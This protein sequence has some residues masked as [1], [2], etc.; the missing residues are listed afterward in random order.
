MPAHY[1]FHIT[2]EGNRQHVRRRILLWFAKMDEGYLFHAANGRAYL[3]ERNEASKIV[4]DMQAAIEN[5]FDKAPWTRADSRVISLAVLAG[6]LTVTIPMQNIWLLGAN[7]LAL[8]GMVVWLQWLF[9]GRAANA[10]RRVRK[11]ATIRLARSCR[12]ALDRKIARAHRPTPLWRNLTI[13]LVAIMVGLGVW[14]MVGDDPAARLVVLKVYT[15]FF[16][17]A[18]AICVFLSDRQYERRSAQLR[19]MLDNRSGQVRHDRLSR[20]STRP[21]AESP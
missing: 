5:A 10:L 21:A 16:A 2:V 7:A 11:D 18:A 4:C 13:A 14:V 6:L 1:P 12:P 17:V 15:G 20:A 19:E 3:L 8:A 9:H